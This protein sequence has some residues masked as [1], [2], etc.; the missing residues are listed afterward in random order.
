MNTG[1]DHGIRSEVT[2]DEAKKI[3]RAAAEKPRHINTVYHDLNRAADAY[4]IARFYQTNWRR[5]SNQ[6]EVLEKVAN[7][8]DALLASLELLGHCERP[9]LIFYAG[10]GGDPARNAGDSARELI[11]AVENVLEAMPPDK[12]GPIPHAAPFRPCIAHLVFAYQT[13]TKTT[14]TVPTMSWDDIAGKYR[15]GFLSFIRAFLETV[16]PKE[17][18]SLKDGALGKA[19]ERALHVVTGSRQ[20]T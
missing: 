1:N 11:R 3:A 4:S 16:D 6:K 13:L 14:G 18:K 15:G 12:G 20:R 17:S 2:L 10:I 7:S 19:V 8:A 5:L 9:Q